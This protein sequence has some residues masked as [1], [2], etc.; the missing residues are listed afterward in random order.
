MDANFKKKILTSSECKQ[1]GTENFW[2]INFQVK[3]I[4]NWKWP[5]QMLDLTPINSPVEG[6]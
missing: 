6:T 5:T 4:K 2:S 3:K 1:L